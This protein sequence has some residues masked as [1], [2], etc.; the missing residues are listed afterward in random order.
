MVQTHHSISGADRNGQIEIDCL[1]DQ[2][3]ALTPIEIKSGHT[4]VADFFQPLK[5]WNALANANPLNS[6]LIYGGEEVQKRAVG[7][8]IG[9]RQAGTLLTN[10]L[11]H[12]TPRNAH[13][14]HGS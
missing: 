12:S 5:K 8:V 14:N 3:T 7:N 9:W 10:L 6:Y 13:E 1:V 11:Q 4:I 2:G